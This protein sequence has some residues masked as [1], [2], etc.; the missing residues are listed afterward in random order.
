MDSTQIGIIKQAC[1][2]VFSSLLQCLDGTNLKCRS[3]APYAWAISYTRHTKGHLWVR[4]SVLHWYLCISWRATIPSWYLWGLFSPYFL[5][6]LWV[7]PAYIGPDMACLPTGCWWCR[8][9]LCHHPYQLSCRWGPQQPPHHLQPPQ[10]PLS[11]GQ[12]FWGWWHSFWG[13]PQLG[14][15]PPACPQSHF[16][17]CH[18]EWSSDQ[19]AFVAGF[20]KLPMVP[21][22]LVNG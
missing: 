4:S 16:H 9:C 7:L 13:C 3:Y 11:S 21:V 22:F 19:L 1:Q 18:P 6:S 8:S 17:P 12:L 14:D 20:S 5:N 15:P 2:V 10:L